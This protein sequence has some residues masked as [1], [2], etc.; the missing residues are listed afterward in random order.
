VLGGR[1][2]LDRDRIGQILHDEVLFP[3]A[4]EPEGRRVHGGLGVDGDRV[5]DVTDIPKRHPAFEE[6]HGKQRITGG[7]QQEN[8]LKSPHDKISR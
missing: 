7:E 6:G 8:M 1:D 3:D 4:L 2:Q 5:V